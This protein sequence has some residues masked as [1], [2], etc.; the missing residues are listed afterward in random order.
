MTQSSIWVTEREHDKKLLSVRKKCCL[1]KR[2]KQEYYMLEMASYHQPP[3][4]GAFQDLL[5]CH[6][7]EKPL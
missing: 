5:M 4:Y 1:S 2:K 7:E 3:F 6:K